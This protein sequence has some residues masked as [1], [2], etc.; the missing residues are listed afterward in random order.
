MP[1]NATKEQT[2][3]LKKLFPEYRIYTASDLSEMYDVD[4]A[5][6]KRYIMANGGHKVGLIWV[7]TEEQLIRNGVKVPGRKK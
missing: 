2:E 6:A 3:R 1:S 7:I 5:T 4:H